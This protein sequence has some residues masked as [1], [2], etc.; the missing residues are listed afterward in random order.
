MTTKPKRKQAAGPAPIPHSK[1]P[2][3]P[4]PP[5]AVWISA[6]QLRN[7]FGARSSMWL[8]RKLKN[9]SDFPRPTYFGRLMFFEIAK[10]EEYEQAMVRGK[11]PSQNF[12]LKGY[13]RQTGKGLKFSDYPD[14][15][16]ML[17]MAGNHK[18]SEWLSHQP[19]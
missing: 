12:S 17:R 19:V 18:A 3:K 15:R 8:V 9:D 4:V 11:F 13:R 2:P 16:A 14:D 10:L 5:D 6:T 1:Q 7:R